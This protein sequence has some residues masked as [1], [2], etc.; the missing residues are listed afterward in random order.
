MT[1]KPW[2]KK[3]PDFWVCAECGCKFRNKTG[4]IRRFCSKSCYVS[5]QRKLFYTKGLFQPKEKHWNWNG[6][7]PHCRICNKET[8]YNRKLGLCRACFHKWERGKNAPNW[9][10][11]ITNYPYPYEFRSL[12]KEI[13]K[14]DGYKCRM[15][16]CSQEK[17]NRGL[18]VHHID[19]NKYNIEPNN[20]ITLCNKCH[21]RTHIHRSYWIGFFT[22]NYS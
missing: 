16:G 8:G 13:R 19:Y 5:A 9:Q 3:Y 4:H 10:G 17:N 11:G 14:R 22:A 18:Q 7:R 15:C 6:G 21:G 12:R 1:N 20:L 2:N